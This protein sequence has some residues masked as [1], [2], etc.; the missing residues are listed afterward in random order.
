[1]AL[2]N[3]GPKPRQFKSRPYIPNRGYWWAWIA[4]QSR[5]LCRWTVTDLAE[6]DRIYA[7]KK[8]HCENLNS[9]ADKSNAISILP[10]RAKV[11]LT[12][13]DLVN[14]Y[15]HHRAAHVDHDNPGKRIS[16][17]TYSGYERA[18]RWLSEQVGPMAVSDLTPQVFTMLD[19]KAQ[20]QYGP[21]QHN[22]IVSTTRMMFKWAVD[23]DHL[24]ALPRYG[25]DFCSTRQTVRLENIRQKPAQMFI[26]AQINALL[27]H[28]DP[29][30]KAM[31]YLG[32]NCAYLQSDCAEL[33]ITFGD[34]PTNKI[35]LGENPFIRFDR[36]KTGERRKCTLWPETVKAL[37]EVIGDRKEGLVFVT[38]RGF[39]LIH[40]SKSF[41]AEGNLVKS[42]NCDPTTK[43]FR[44]LCEC[45][46]VKKKGLEDMTKDP[47]YGI[48]FSALRSTFETVA[49]SNRNLSVAEQ[50][51]IAW[52]MGHRLSGV[53]IAKM[54]DRYLQDIDAENLRA[55]TDQVREWLLKKA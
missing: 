38:R 5:S 43:K 48:G 24:P 27:A 52:A 41:D 13:E 55:V 21:D 19:E 3:I 18:L 32:I 51:A 45:A 33:P 35:H 7:E 11:N 4:G 9:S 1:M 31:I 8:Q 25:S 20:K 46:G 6:L 15:L 17:V 14:L 22:H 28:A 37:K 10:E 44:E 49:F 30:M 12:V 23:N 2:K 26:A 36:V 47:M 34:H 29:Q 40:Q 50:A 54:A 42:V 53:N 16:G 39:P